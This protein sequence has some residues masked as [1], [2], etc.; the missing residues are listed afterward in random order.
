METEHPEDGQSP[1][2]VKDD[3]SIAALMSLDDEK[4]T[5]YASCP[6]EGCGEALLFTELE[7]HIEMH[8][9]EH[10]TGDE[11]STHSSKRLKLQPEI[12]AAFD[13]KLSYALRNLDDVDER[14]PYES[15][16]SDRQAVAKATWKGLLKMPDSSSKSSSTTKSNR[17]RLGAS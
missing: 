3:A 16:P 9:E 14:A 5:Q 13:T 6:V 17:R 2:V 4:D 12:E 8:G 7:S 15:A 1:F 10:D 11:L